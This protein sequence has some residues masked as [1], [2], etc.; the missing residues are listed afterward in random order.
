MFQTWY[1]MRYLRPAG[2]RV[3]LF[4]EFIRAWF[5]VEERRQFLNEQWGALG[6]GG[7][8]GTLSKCSSI[9][10]LAETPIERR[11]EARMKAIL[12]AGRSHGPEAAEALLTAALR[13]GPEDIRAHLEF[14]SP[15]IQYAKTGDEQALARL[16]EPER[17]AA[18]KIAASILE[19]KG[20]SAANATAVGMSGGQPHLQLQ[21]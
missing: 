4:V 2:R 8:G 6:S 1:Q 16:P 13:G 20:V 12:N 5:T 7:K 14:L 21:H 9:G 10:A 15:A 19:K 11:L 18:K 17:D 3:E